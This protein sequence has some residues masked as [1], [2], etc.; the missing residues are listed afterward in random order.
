MKRNTMAPC[1]KQTITNYNNTTI[2][3]INNHTVYKKNNNINK[4]IDLLKEELKDIRVIYD[5]CG[6]ISDATGIT[7]HG[8]EDASHQYYDD[9]KSTKKM[10]YIEKIKVDDLDKEIVEA[11]YRDIVKQ[12]SIFPSSVYNSIVEEDNTSPIFT[13]YTA[14]SRPEYI[15]MCPNPRQIPSENI[16]IFKKNNRKDILDSIPLN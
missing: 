1:F 2:G 14:F 10:S 16:N 12:D 3:E 7:K 6:D 9:I 15:E 11:H 5:A 13:N 4:L 8:T